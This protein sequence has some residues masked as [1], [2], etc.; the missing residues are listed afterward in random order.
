MDISERSRI[1]SPQLLAEQY[2][3]S[4]NLD[5]RIDDAAALST[6]C[7]S[8]TR[9]EIPE[10]RRAEFAEYVERL[11]CERGGEM[12]IAKDAGMFIAA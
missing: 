6:F 3:T 12:R 11:M 8:V 10:D 2:R 9:A 4:A 5:A 7:L 1:A